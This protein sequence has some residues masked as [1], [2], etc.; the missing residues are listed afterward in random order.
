MRI[1]LFKCGIEELEVCLNFKP[2]KKMLS[3]W[4]ERLSTFSDD[5]YRVAIHWMIKDDSKV[6][7]NNLRSYLFRAS[8]RI[9]EKNRETAL[10][11]DYFGGGVALKTQDL[12][13]QS[14]KY[15][16]LLKDC[17]KIRNKA[18]RN[19]SLDDLKSLWLADYKKL[20][21]Y[22]TEAE[23]TELVE[24]KDYHRLDDLNVLNPKFNPHELDIKPFITE[25]NQAI[26]A[27]YTS[28]ENLDFNEMIL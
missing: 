10:R 22:T 13:S 9:D 25:G 1:E 27:E 15:M 14:R 5:A 7:F 6:T 11:R 16:G 18:E 26:E 28:V 19:Q 4:Y 20:P 24:S 21:G 23:V 2:S 12:R 8:V 3:G 17:M